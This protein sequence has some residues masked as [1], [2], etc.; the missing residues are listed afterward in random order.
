MVLSS[1]PC[2]WDLGTRSTRCGPFLR[3]GWYSHVEGEQGGSHSSQGLCG[4]SISVLISWAS[5]EGPGQRWATWVPGPRGS[6]GIVRLEQWGGGPPP[7]L[8]PLPGPYHL[9]APQQVHFH[10]PSLPNLCAMVVRW[11]GGG[12]FF[13][14]KMAVRKATVARNHWLVSAKDLSCRHAAAEQKTNKPHAVQRL[15]EGPSCLGAGSSRDI[16]S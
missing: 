12:I 2:C 13:K 10:I 3:W 7:L 14:N 11:G 15:G 8:L 1:R 6:L 5:G 9:V 16:A 4:Q